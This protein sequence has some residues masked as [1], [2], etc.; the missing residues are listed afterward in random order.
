MAHSTMIKGGISEMTATIA[1]MSSGWE[2]AFPSVDEAYDLVAKNPQTSAW[3]TLQVKSIRRR[4][5][6]NNDLVIYATNGKGEPYTPDSC[7]WIVGVEDSTVY[8]VPCSGLREYW[9]VDGRK[10][11]K[12]NANNK[13]AV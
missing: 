10:W 7:D 6:R 13:E 2:V 3:E 8:L 4:S 12:L 11:T 9:S 5:D 1:L